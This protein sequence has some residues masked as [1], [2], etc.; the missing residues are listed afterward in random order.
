MVSG[1]WNWPFFTCCLSHA[2]PC[3]WAAQTVPKKRDLPLSTQPILEIKIRSNTISSRWRKKIEQK[4]KI[5]PPSGLQINRKIMLVSR[6]SNFR[7]RKWQFYEWKMAG[8][9]KV[10]CSEKKLRWLFAIMSIHLQKVAV[11]VLILTMWNLSWK[12][13]EAINHTSQR[14]RIPRMIN[15]A[16]KSYFLSANRRSGCDTLDVRIKYYVPF[17]KALEIRH[18]R[19]SCTKICSATLNKRYASY[20]P[21][22]L[23]Y[24]SWLNN[25]APEETLELE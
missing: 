13:F 15:C 23:Y 16:I 18:A 19:G 1:T 12:P 17:W 4:N 3:D 22:V 7:H 8:G 2:E 11:P 10:Q 5:I 20:Q 25:K 9:K 14:T 24:S 21:K 6:L